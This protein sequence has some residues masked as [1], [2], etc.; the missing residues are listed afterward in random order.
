MMLVFPWGERRDLAAAPTCANVF[1][2]P[3]AKRRAGARRWPRL[4]DPDTGRCRKT[5]ETLRILRVP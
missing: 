4:L 5:N 2:L 3:S 1:A